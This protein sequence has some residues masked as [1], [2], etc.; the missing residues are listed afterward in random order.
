MVSNAIQSW[1]LEKDDGFAF[2]ER[3]SVIELSEAIAALNCGKSPGYDL[4]TTEHLKYG[5]DK[6]VTVLT[7][8]YN[9]ILA[10]EYIPK[11]FRIGTQIPLYKGKNLCSLDPNNYRGITL[12]T[13][14]NKLFEIVTW[15]RIKVW[16]HD[17]QVISPLQ[18]ACTKG[19]SCLHTAAILQESIAVGPGGGTQVQRGCA[20]A[21]RI[22]RKKGSFFK[23]SACP[24]FCKRRVLFCT[25][26]RS[27][28]VKIPL[29]STK[30]TR[31]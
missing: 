20:P 30:Y 23:T 11:N 24:R 8:L 1:V 18:G 13:S 14:F 28:G 31:L 3:L 22:L 17:N 12:L 21:L 16:W 10:I 25:Q 27:M 19:L 26:V 5:G 15:K 9:R 29:Q 2:I 7:K 4:I 6:L